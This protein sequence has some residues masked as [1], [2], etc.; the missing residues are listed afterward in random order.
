MVR[1]FPH[2]QR[3]AAENERHDQ[4]CQ[5][6]A[7]PYTLFRG[8]KCAL[9]GVGKSDALTRF[10]TKCLNDFDCAKGFRNDGADAGDII[11]AGARCLFQPPAEKNDWQY[12]NR[13]ARQK[14]N[15]QTWSQAK[16]QCHAADADKDI[17][18]RNGHRGANNL[19]D[20]RRICGHPARDFA[21]PILFKKAWRKP[22][23]VALNGNADVADDAFAQPADKV[24]TE[25]CRNTD[26]NDNAQQQIKIWRGVAAIFR[27]ALINNQPQAIWDSQCR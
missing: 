13:N 8:C 26:D 16:K 22:K 10:L 27:K 18:Q 5:E 11:L 7:Y 14:P 6:R 15:G 2:Q 20:N 24:K 25:C 1:A 21:G 9:D 19:F 3:D 23:Q 4:R 12:N 17:P